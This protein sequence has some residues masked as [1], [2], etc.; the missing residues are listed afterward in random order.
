MAASRVADGTTRLLG[1]SPAGASSSS[2]RSCRWGLP[3]LRFFGRKRPEPIPVD[4]PLDAKQLKRH[5]E[6]R[7]RATEPGHFE[8]LARDR[9]LVMECLS[10][11]NLMHPM[12]KLLK[13]TVSW[14]SLFGGVLVVMA[15]APECICKTCYC[16]CDFPDKPLPCGHNEAERICE[17]CYHRFGVLHPFPGEF[18]YGYREYLYRCYY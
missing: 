15:D 2:C 1:S 5:R 17:M 8:R 12:N 10:H 4:K 3:P 18:A 11:Y 14:V 7:I 13:A 16:R 6:G 9:R